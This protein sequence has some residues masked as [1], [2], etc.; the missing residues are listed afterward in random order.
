MSTPT[1]ILPTLLNSLKSK[2]TMADLK[3][4]VARN[5]HSGLE[6]RV[7]S[8]FDGMTDCVESNP[9][10]RWVEA[11]PTTRCLENT[12]GIEGVWVVGNSRDRIKLTEVD[13]RIGFC[14]YNCCGSFTIAIKP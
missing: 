2:H 6:L 1:R 11:K 5:Y 7:E 3:R 12:L 9:A 13:G 10:A 4:F 8:Q 14:V